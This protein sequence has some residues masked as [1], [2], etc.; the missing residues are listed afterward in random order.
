M[1]K[2]KTTVI[3]WPACQMLMD[4]KDFREN[5]ALC[6]SEKFYEEYGDC[7]YAVNNEWLE[8]LNPELTDDV[9]SLQES[10]EGPE[11]DFDSL[12]EEDGLKTI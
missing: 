3:C 11:V 4:Q 12:E 7:A 5:S 2:K 10:Y 8:S 1:A 6:S 9:F